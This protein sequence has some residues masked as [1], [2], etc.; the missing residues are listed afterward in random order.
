MS[1]LDAL[2]SNQKMILR[3]LVAIS[4]QYIVRIAMAIQLVQYL[5]TMQPQGGGT[6]AGYDDSGVV[7]IWQNVHQW[8]LGYVNRLH[9]LLTL[10]YLYLKIFHYV[11]CSSSCDKDETAN[12]P[13]AEELFT[14][15]RSAV[16]P[17][18][19]RAVLFFHC[20]NGIE[21]PQDG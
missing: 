14:G 18:L 3:P 2:D 20:C 15:Y 19:Q 8:A 10:V 17:L 7:E 12:Q 21:L 4:D 5:L 11:L 16:Q 6:Q 9:F 1:L 13:T